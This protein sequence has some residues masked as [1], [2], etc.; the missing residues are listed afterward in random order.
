MT[1]VL[2]A[3]AL[4]AFE[5]RVPHAVARLEQSLATGERWLTHGGVIGQVWRDPA[6]QVPLGRVIRATDVRSLDASLGRAAGRLLAAA[7][8]GDVIDAALIALMEDGDEVF[9]SD[10]DDLRALVDAA[11]LEVDIRVV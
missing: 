8:T 1:L 7:G 6:R 11:R 2:D 4:I 5:R 3:G 9:T 10:P